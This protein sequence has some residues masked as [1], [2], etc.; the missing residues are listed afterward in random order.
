M[1]ICFISSMYPPFV[2]GG[3]EIL[4][5]REAEGLSQK[6]HQIVVITT[7]PSKT[8]SRI[9]EING[10]R[11]Y[12]VSPFNLYLPYQHQRIPLMMKPLFHVLDLWNPHSYKL[13]GKI[14]DA[15]KPDIVHINNYKGFSLSTFGAVKKSGAKLVFT[16]H[17]Y[18]LICARGTLLHPSGTICHHPREICRIYNRIQKYLA[19]GKPNMITS[20]TEFVIDKL[21][22]N[23]LFAGIKAVKLPVALRVNSD[24]PRKNYDTIKV[25]YVGQ[26]NRVKGVH[27]L[28]E[29]F[30]KIEQRNVSLSIVGSGQ[31]FECMERLASSDPRIKL[32]GFIPNEALATHYREANMM[33]VP[34][35]WYDMAQLVIGEGFSFGIP[36][37]GSRIGGIPELINEGY[38][39][40]LFEP[41]DSEELQERLGSLIRNP[42]ELKKLEHGAFESS[43]NYD[44]KQHIAGLEEMYEECISARAF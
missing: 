4:V 6:G 18:S 31:D 21:R 32:L 28:I 34:S 23:G 41:G 30:K 35:M 13:V 5:K 12:R 44:I 11:V 8:S 26:V 7:S 19:A 36:V 1:K 42:A 14:L 24:T 38:N 3:A 9:E 20:P 43:K 17:D 25:L 37:I 16:A 22:T 33:V 29:A 2:L 39:G 15:E 10:V 27:V 40:L